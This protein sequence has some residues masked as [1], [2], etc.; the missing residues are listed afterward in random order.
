MRLLLA[1]PTHHLIMLPHPRP[2]YARLVSA[3][4]ME[5]AIQTAAVISFILVIM[6]IQAT[7]KLLPTAQLTRAM[8]ATG[9]TVVTMPRARLIA[10]A[11]VVTRATNREATAATTTTTGRLIMA[12]TTTTT[13]TTPTTP[14]TSQISPGSGG[15]FRS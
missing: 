11:S 9:I 12:T 6:V 4:M 2:T 14:A 1:A 15:S 8:E 13:T 3:N 5:I 7:V 10:A